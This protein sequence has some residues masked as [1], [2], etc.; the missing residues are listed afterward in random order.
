M[1]FLKSILKRD[2][3][4]NILCWL[5]AQYIRVVYYTGRWRLEGSQEA[6]QIMQSGQPYIAAFWHGRLLMIPMLPCRMDP[7]HV[8]ISGHGDGRLIAQVMDHIGVFTVEGS[9]SRGGARALIEMIRLIRDGRNVA[10]TP[11]GP[12]GP[13]MQASA[14]AIALAKKTGA[15]ILPCT[16]STRWGKNIKSWDRFLVPWPFTRGIYRM[17]EPIYVVETS[18]ENEEENAR[19]ALEQSLNV[20]TKQADTQ[21]QRV[22]VSPMP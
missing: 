13:R 9:S 14:G 22:P 4:K 20:L 2:G 21:M 6:Q 15:P 11:D 1:R 8:L 5:V 3:V 18:D 16:F 7:V 19:L 10:I 17:G 12:R